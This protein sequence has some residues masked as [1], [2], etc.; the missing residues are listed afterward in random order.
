MTVTEVAKL[1]TILSELGHGKVTPE[2]AAAWHMS[3]GFL[4]YDV[5]LEAVRDASR[6]STIEY[7]EPKHVVA[8]AQA[9]THRRE[10]LAAK[11]QLRGEWHGDPKPDNFDEWAEASTRLSR[12]E[13]AGD[14]EAAHRARMDIAQGQA[15]Y[16]DQLRAAGI[17]PNHPRHPYK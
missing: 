1:L 10:R 5:A 16:N 15:K 12:A 2:K 17:D 13:K 4:D 6:N 11:N 8:H 14:E 3:L 7:I 9:V